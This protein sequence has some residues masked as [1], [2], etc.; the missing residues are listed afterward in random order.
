MEKIKQLYVKY[1]RVILY[2]IFG[3]LT[4]LVNW[5]CY[6]VL[7]HFID[8]DG[9]VVNAVSVNAIIVNAICW[10]AAVLFAYVT[11]RK[12]V[13]ES[14]AV[15]FKKIFQEFVKFILARVA[16]GL[17]ETFGFSLFY[18]IFG[19][20]ASILG[21]DGAASKVIISVIVIILN[22]IFS[23]LLV[24]RTGKEKEPVAKDTIAKD[25]IVKEERAE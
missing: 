9:N 3:V 16:T 17:I 20:K 15:G 18:D 14:K 1:K 21:I 7:V 23:K 12:Y 25:S 22:Y 10:L 8:I 5:V 11:N 24:F 19:L 4:T 2:L 6:T 13:F